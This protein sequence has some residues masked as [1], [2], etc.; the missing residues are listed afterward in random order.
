MPNPPIKLNPWIALAEAEILSIYG[1][2]ASASVKQKTLNKFGRTL[3]ADLG[4]KTTLMQL[5][6]TAVNETYATGNTIDRLVSDDVADTVQTIVL[7]GHYLSVDNNLVFHVQEKALNGQTPVTLDQPLVRLTRMFVKPTGTFAAP[8]AEL[9]GGVYGYDSVLT[10]VTLGVPQTA[11]AVK[12]TIIAG[13]QQSEKAATSLSF[14]DY[15]LITSVSAA[16]S[17]GTAPTVNVD[18]DMEFRE[19]GGV[20]RPLGLELSLRGGAGASGIVRLEPYLIIPAN[21]DVRMVALSD[22]NDATLSGG[23]SSILAIQTP[24]P[25]L[26]AAV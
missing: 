26:P 18:V 9:Q 23:W 2:Q 17:N 10:V 4:V 13:V 3:N 12:C 25:D 19:L 8:V 7:E 15:M 16:I 11:A 14:R 21:S 6:G 24:V 5:P 1:V 22:T 20:F